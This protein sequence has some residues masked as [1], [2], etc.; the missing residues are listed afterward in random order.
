MPHQQ[1]NGWIPAEKRSC[2]EQTAQKENS[3]IHHQQVWHNSLCNR[4]NRKSRKV[5]YP[6]QIRQTAAQA[7][8]RISVF[9]YCSEKRCPRILWKAAQK[10]AW[11]ITRPSADFTGY[12]EKT[13]RRWITGNHLRVFCRDAG[14]YIISKSAFLDFLSSDYYNGIQLK[15]DC[16]LADLHSITS[17]ITK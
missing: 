12:T 9:R 15:T 10:R 8:S 13:V 3:L 16:H 11:Y 17:I 5:C 14:K 1:T 6:A 4:Q 2:A 7:W